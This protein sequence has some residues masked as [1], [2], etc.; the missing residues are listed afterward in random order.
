[1]ITEFI[2]LLQPSWLVGGDSQSPSE[3]LLLPRA[4]RWFPECFGLQAGDY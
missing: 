3:S 4:F 2:R 1:M